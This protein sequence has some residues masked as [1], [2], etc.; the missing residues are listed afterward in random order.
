MPITEHYP[1]ATG[2]GR[3]TQGGWEEGRTDALCSLVICFDIYL[4]G[5]AWIL[6][7]DMHWSLE[8]ENQ[9]K[10]E[11]THRIFPFYSYQQ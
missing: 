2:N 7:K 6:Q 11:V 4:G 9:K 8:V 1:F 10:T 3:T 5:S